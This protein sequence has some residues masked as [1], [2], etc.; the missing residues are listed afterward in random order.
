MKVK[1]ALIDIMK[2]NVGLRKLARKILSLKGRIKYSFYYHSY[3][4]DGKL[5]IFESFG[6][7]SYSDSPKAMYEEILKDPKYKDYKLVWS[8]IDKEEK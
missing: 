4:V 3:S 1:A 7:R 2:K 5:I 6:G 8:F